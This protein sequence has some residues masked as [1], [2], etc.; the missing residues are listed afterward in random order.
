MNKTQISQRFGWTVGRV[1]KF[2]KPEH[3]HLRYGFHGPYTEYEYSLPAVIEAEHDSR[4]LKAAGRYLGL[5]NLTY[6]ELVSLRERAEEESRRAAAEAHA[7]N[8]AHKR[9]QAKQEFAKKYAPGRLTRAEWDERTA[10]KKLCASVRGGLRRAGYSHPLFDGW[11]TFTPEQITPYVDLLDDSKRLSVESCISRF[12]VLWK[13]GEGYCNRLGSVRRIIVPVK[14][15]IIDCL[16]S[17][18]KREGW[19]YG[20][21]ANV[22]YIETPE[23]QVSFHLRGAVPEYPRYAGEWS[24]KKDSQQILERLIGKHSKQT[25]TEERT[26]HV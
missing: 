23:G 11:R 13:A 16:V 19:V 22:L 24:G 14:E 26:G 1:N 17:Q 25:E 10:F 6:E 2:L 15:K 7:R 3:T 5:K 12:Y 4:W 18:A 8:L 21:K 20:R 9:E